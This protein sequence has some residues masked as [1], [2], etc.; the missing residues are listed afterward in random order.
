[1][2]VSGV[3]ATLGKAVRSFDVPAETF[4]LHKLSVLL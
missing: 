2:L 1:M 3:D 4:P